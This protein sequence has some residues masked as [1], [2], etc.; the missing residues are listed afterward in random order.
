MQNQDLIFPYVWEMLNT[1]LLSPKNL[2]HFGLA[3]IVGFSLLII[4]FI[5]THA[6]AGAKSPSSLIGLVVGTFITGCLL[7]WAAM[8]RIYILPRIENQSMHLFYLISILVLTFFIIV[9]PV[10]KTMFRA[11]YI[12][13]LM[14]WICALSV[15]GLSIT[16]I[17][18]L[19]G[20]LQSEA[21]SVKELQAYGEKLKETFDSQVEEKVPK[22]QEKFKELPDK[23]QDGLKG[24]EPSPANEQP[25]SQ[26]NTS[27]SPPQESSD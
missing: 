18:M 25:N 2:L 8:I 17:D 5:K 3:L 9:I 19:M 12:S 7:I 27:P 21:L 23:I 26:Q 13:S 4:V 11:S 15:A 16:V 22:I 10:T 6:L 20:S 14:A 1:V 24:G